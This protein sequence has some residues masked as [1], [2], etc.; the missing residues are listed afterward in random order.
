MIQ[1]GPHSSG[2]G[3]KL[4]HSRP[5]P[6]APAAEASPQ[7]QE[8]RSPSLLGSENPKD[9]PGAAAAAAAAAGSQSESEAAAPAALRLPRIP[10]LREPLPKRRQSRL[11]KYLASRDQYMGKYTRLSIY[12]KVAARM[13][14]CSC[15]SSA[16]SDSGSSSSSETTRRRRPRSSS[17]SAAQ[18][19]SS[20][21]ETRLATPREHRGPPSPGT[22]EGGP[23][24][25]RRSLDSFVHAVA[26][27]LTA[28]P[29]ARGGPPSQTGGAPRGAPGGPR[30]PQSDAEAE[31]PQA[32]QEDPEEAY[33]ADYE[34]D[35]GEYD[36][37][38]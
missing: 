14:N 2:R 32:P 4:V 26:E 25:K 38:F 23:H 17:S 6:S 24:K 21:R 36:E 31:T 5:A 15:S 18:Q 27:Q 13:G 3:A 30:T 1:T 8:T 11:E 22:Q 33:D 12:F 37:F 35:A 29:A 10:S 34:S 28:S 7:S 20:Y 19:Q 16:E 9:V